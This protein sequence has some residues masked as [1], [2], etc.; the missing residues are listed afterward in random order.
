MAL[1]C[2]SSY[3]VGCVVARHFDER[4][5]LFAHTQTQTMTAARTVDDDCP[6]FEIVLLN[7]DYYDIGSDKRYSLWNYAFV[8]D[9]TL[10]SWMRT[11]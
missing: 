7:Y 1:F 8:L 9:V 3:S 10:F 11:I 5:T 2:G 4:W 6:S